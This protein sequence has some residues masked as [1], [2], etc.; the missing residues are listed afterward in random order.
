M[1]HVRHDSVSVT[2]GVSNIEM[3]ILNSEKLD[4]HP[5]TEVTSISVLY[6]Y[7]SHL[8]ANTQNLWHI[9]ILSNS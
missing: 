3:P 4:I 5:F 2:S 9:A 8:L 6:N 7:H 1:S